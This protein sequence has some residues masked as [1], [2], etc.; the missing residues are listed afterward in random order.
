MKYLMV[1]AAAPLILLSGCG[2]SNDGKVSISDGKGGTTEI[3]TAGAT[4]TIT[5]ADGQKTTVSSTATLPDYAP[6][7]PGSTM[8]D[9]TNIASGQGKMTTAVMTTADPADK[10]IA[11]YKPKLVAAGLP[12]TMETTTAEGAMIMAGSGMPGASSSSSGR[13]AAVSV[14][15]A[16]GKSEISLV[17]NEPGK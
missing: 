2:G 16:D 12:V 11:F 13:S 8:G 14:K 1:L 17:L 15:V 10:I 6:Q 3:A 7:Y 9:Q 4:S 5:T